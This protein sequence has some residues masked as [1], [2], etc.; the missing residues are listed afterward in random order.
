MFNTR[1]PVALLEPGV[2]AETLNPSC[3][4]S[5]GTGLYYLYGKCSKL[6][7]NRSVDF[8]FAICLNLDVKTYL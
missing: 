8:M 5:E 4:P 1:S 2:L 3:V 7:Q 6:M